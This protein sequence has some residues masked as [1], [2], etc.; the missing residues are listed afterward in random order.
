MDSMPENIVD[1][2]LYVF[3][4]AREVASARFGD[5]AA[6]EVGDELDLRLRRGRVRAR[7]IARL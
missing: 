2:R 3:L 1:I 4:I 7:T 6:V 5:A